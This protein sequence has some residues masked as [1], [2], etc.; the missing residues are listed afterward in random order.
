MTQADARQ[1][2]QAALNRLR[3]DQ[4]APME[5][6]IEG[7]DDPVDYHIDNIVKTGEGLWNEAVAS[8]YIQNLEA[9]VEQELQAPGGAQS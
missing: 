3:A 6:E 2:I 4:S 9:Q 8:D 5:T 1:K 7:Y